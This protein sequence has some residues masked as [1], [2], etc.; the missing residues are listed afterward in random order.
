[1]FLRERLSLG[2]F[3]NRR[4]LETPAV[5]AFDPYELA[6]E[7][8]TA[9]VFVWQ[10]RLSN[11]TGSIDVARRLVHTASTL[12]LGEAKDNVLSALGRLEE[13]ETSHAEIAR[14]VLTRLGRPEAVAVDVLGPLPNESAERSFARQV[15]AALCIAET[16]SA[17]RYAAVRDAT[18]LEIPHACIDVLL[19]DEVQHG[20]LGF[21]LL[22]LAI[23]R[24]GGDDGHAFVESIITDALRLLDRTVGMDAERRGML[25]ARPQ[26]A[27]NPG[28]VEPAIDALAF[29]DAVERTIIPSFEKAGIDAAGAFRRRFA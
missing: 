27:C 21:S 11:E 29:Y 13:D 3:T 2:P 26:P 28:V 23:D 8:M 20:V 6:A 10:R 9:A 14:A 24:L 16:V 12:D 19:K 4:R 15:V 7:A 17:A 5:D 25:E 1:M 22:P 18:D